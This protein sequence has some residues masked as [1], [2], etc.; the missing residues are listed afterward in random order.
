MREKLENRSLKG[1]INV[2][3]KYDDGT[4]RMWCTTK[5]QVVAHIVSIVR[6]YRAQGYK[7]TLRQLHYQLVSN[8]WIVNHDTAY[9]KLGNILDDCRYAGVIDWNDI[10]DRGR[11]PY[12]PFSVDDLEEGLTVLKNSYR[13][14]RQDGQDN[15]IELWTEK[16]ALSGILRRSTEKYHIQLVVNKGYTSS[17][18]IHDAYS[19][20]AEQ[21]KAGKKVIILY[22]GDHDP[23]G[24]DMVR[25]ITDRLRLFLSAGRQLRSNDEL[26]EKMYA[27]WN[28]EEY[29]IYDLR[30]EDFISD[31]CVD[32]LMHDARG[33]I[34][35]AS[36]QFDNGQLLKYLLDHNLFQVKHIGLTMEQIRKY[37][38]PHNPAKLTDAR[39]AKYVA[40]H[41][42]M[43]WEVDALKP[44]VL[45]EIVEGHIEEYIDLDL[46]NGVIEREE[47]DQEN[48]Q[49]MID[50][51]I[52][53][54]DK[55]ESDDE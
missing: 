46:Y 45:T 37:K 52:W 30:S 20:I 25:D 4:V 54:S 18:A 48:I 55:Q 13:L 43:S 17:S 44:N 2:T 34:D 26:M 24:L 42:K 9:K 27:W 23:S 39:A 22:F 7:L 19:R 33:D 6:E 15:Y 11:Q 51:H 14:D 8:N 53:P 28:K 16:D 31:K 1:P 12:I 10:E 3:C 21:I 5:E 32:I 29:S 35:E 40:Q 38:L 47:V 41:G 49:E 50:E 36:E